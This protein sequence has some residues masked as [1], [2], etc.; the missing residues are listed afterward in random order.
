LIFQHFSRLQLTVIITTLFSA[1][2]SGLNVSL[3]NIL[4]PYQTAQSTVQFLYLYLA[5]ANHKHLIISAS[6]PRLFLKDN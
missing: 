5:I 4:S 6:H 1:S 3:P 2:Q